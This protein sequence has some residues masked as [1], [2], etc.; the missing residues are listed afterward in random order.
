MYLL[1]E[2]EG[3]AILKKYGV[4]ACDNEF[5]GIIDWI[6]SRK[7]VQGIFE[8]N[9]FFAFCFLPD[10]FVSSGQN[11]SDCPG[12]R[13]TLRHGVADINHQVYQHLLKLGRRC[14]SP[15][16]QFYKHDGTMERTLR[17]VNVWLEEE[18]MSRST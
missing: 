12:Q 10:L 16:G 15:F 1:S 8:K 3:N 17:S 13:A 14:N 18:V 2:Q 9:I 5:E 7:Y 11:F 6:K 4:F